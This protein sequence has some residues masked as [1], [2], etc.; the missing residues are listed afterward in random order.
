MVDK[1]ILEA[2]PPAAL[3]DAAR[4]AAE[5]GVFVDPGVR[6]GYATMMIKARAGDVQALEEAIELLSRSMKILGD[7]RPP[8][9][10]RA[11]ATGI[12]ADP[13]AAQDLI[14][15]A[16]Q[17]RTGQREAAAARRV[18]DHDLAQHIE[19]MMPEGASSDGRPGSW[20]PFAFKTAVLYFHLSKETM[21]AILAGRPFAGA[22]VGRVDDIGPLVLDQVRQWLQ[23][24]NVVVKPVIDLPGMQPVDHYETP[25]AIS[26]AIRLIRQ[27]DS[28]PH[29]SCLSAQQ[30]NEHTVPFMPVDQGG[31][32]GQTDPRRM[33]RMTRI[34]HRIK[35]HAGWTVK[36]LRP[37]SWLYRSPHRYYFVVDHQGTTPLGRLC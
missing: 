26:E 30:D 10:R 17:V 28:F 9:E 6:H 2:D 34:H 13:R 14:A 15:R 11:D 23:H 4:T 8:Q 3:S 18:G 37:G 36:Q 33:S 27:A 24:S 22:A 20:R 19:S 32:P 21:D 1:A 12:I 5:A 25:P 29:G 31:P 16:E 7:T 35:T